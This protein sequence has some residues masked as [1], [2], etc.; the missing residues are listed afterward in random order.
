MTV[1]LGTRGR[2]GMTQREQM[3]NKGPSDPPAEWW[4]RC[5]PYTL[6]C[7]P[8][9]ALGL[10]LEASSRHACKQGKQEDQQP[11]GGHFAAQCFG[12]SV[13]RMHQMGFVQWEPAGQLSLFMAC[14]K[15]PPPKVTWSTHAE[16]V[17][18][19]IRSGAAEACL[20]QGAC[21]PCALGALSSSTGS[22]CQASSTSPGDARIQQAAI[23]APG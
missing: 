23:F 19:A 10:H 11:G 8:M 5:R 13:L 15:W 2:V 1:K 20:H 7:G 16:P 22:I 6:F 3:G 14:T 21:R 17:R 9:R 12:S 18:E 4:Q